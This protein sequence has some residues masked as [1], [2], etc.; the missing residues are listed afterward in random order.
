[1]TETKTRLL[2]HKPGHEDRDQSTCDQGHK[3]N[4]FKNEQSGGGHST[5]A[6]Q[7]HLH[8]QLKDVIVSF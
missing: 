3:V 1:M 4:S 7:K 8:L 5:V 6:I 2:C